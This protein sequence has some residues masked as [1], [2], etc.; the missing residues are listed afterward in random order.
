MQLFY[1]IQ[2]VNIGLKQSCGTMHGA[3]Y[4]INKLDREAETCCQKGLQNHACMADAPENIPQTQMSPP[5]SLVSGVLIYQGEIW[6]RAALKITK[7]KS[8]D[9]QES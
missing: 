1:H 5:P 4:E 2:N 8:I 6:C 9:L 3:R 7:A